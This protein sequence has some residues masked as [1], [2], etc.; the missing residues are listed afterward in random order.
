[1][2]TVTKRFTF[3]YAHE[4][5]DYN[6]KCRNL[7]GHTGI[8]EVEVTKQGK[9]LS[10]ESY[11]GMVID[12]SVLKQIV[13]EE[14]IGILD[15]SYLNDVLWDVPTAENIA[16]WVWDRLERRFGE[17]LVRVRVYETPDSYAEIRR[18]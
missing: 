1:M 3:D 16:R 7:H 6:G 9:V 5:P 11:S 14:V 2:L 15:H 4:L 18:D 10:L 8:L 13:E 12:F 17:G